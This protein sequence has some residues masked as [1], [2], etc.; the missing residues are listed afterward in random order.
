MNALSS[1]FDYFTAMALMLGVL[2]TIHEFGHFIVAKWCGVKVLRFS[3]GFGGAIGIGRY[4]LS[5]TRGDT[6]YRIAWFPLGG[7]VKMLG[8]DPEADAPTGADAQRSLEARPLWQK[9]AIVLAGPAMNLLLPVF[10]FMGFLHVGTPVPLPVLGMVEPNSPAAQAGL[11]AGDR[12][13]AVDG[14]PLRHFG[15]LERAVSEAPGA[16]LR[17]SVERGGAEFETE[18]EAALRTRLDAFG[19]A[20]EAGFIGVHHGRLRADLAL[21]EAG[22]PAER[23]GLRS[24]DRVLSVNGAPV[25]DW[26]AFER[27][28]AAARGV[29]RLEVLRPAGAAVGDAGAS[30]AADAGRA[31][32]DAT[33]GDAGSGDM[34]ADGAAGDADD[35]TGDAAAPS[36]PL[37]AAQQAG[38]R[39]L[40]I[41]APAL[42]DTAL[43]GVMPALVLIRE[44][45]PDS[46][47]ERAGLRVGD[48]V[49]AVDGEPVGSF[50]TFQ[51]SVLASGGRTLEIRY[52]RDGRAGT[53]QVAGEKRTVDVGGVSIERVLI[54][55][56]P[57][58]SV[59][60]GAVAR[61]RVRNP[62]ASFPRAV[63]MTI[64]TTLVF[65]EGVRRIVTGRISAD[66]VSGPIE[67]ARMS[68]VALNESWERFWRLLVLISINLG[69]LNLLPIPVLDGGQAMIFLLEGVKRR[70][71]ALRTRAAIQQVGL[72]LIV[73]LMGLALWNDFSRN[74]SD[75]VAWL[76]GG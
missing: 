14:A 47:A 4:R 70:P 10:V 73:G 30:A 13:L 2:V 6:E 69:I 55:I 35:A 60:P 61:E 3:V 32:G 71:L 41:E 38:A 24:G 36:S 11:L 33:T 45:F 26:P 62:L 75:F 9:L 20:H 53:L 27:A 37:H 49:L 48:L 66:Q 56:R 42:G 63:N 64:D 28:F 17:L 43:L 34:A 74:W 23:A 22:S 76:L 67:I 58:N 15:E 7:Y 50:F 21:P 29:A 8:E 16:V 5:W 40:H 65:L 39:T 19:A 68:Q 18:V 44:V 72:L 1:A 31:V 51:E 46:P 12:V 54:G 52:A 59:F 25:E 57:S